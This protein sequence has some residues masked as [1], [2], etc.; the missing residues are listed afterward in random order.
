MALGTQYCLWCDRWGH[1]H[2]SFNDCDEN[3]KKLARKAAEVAAA[4][5]KAKAT[6][7]PKQ[8]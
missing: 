2:H 7:V 4:V 1:E 6:E 5:A 3:F 8:D